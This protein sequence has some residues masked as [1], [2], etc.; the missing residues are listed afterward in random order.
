MQ[1]KMLQTSDVIMGWGAEGTVAMDTACYHAMGVQ[2]SLTK[3]FHD[4]FKD[5]KSDFDKFSV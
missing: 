5:H 2:N 3:I 1:G 4:Y